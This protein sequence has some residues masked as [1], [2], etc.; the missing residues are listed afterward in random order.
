MLR[1]FKG[2]EIG[3]D[4]LFGLQATDVALGLVVGERHVLLKGKGKPLVTRRLSRLRPLE[5]LGFPLLPC[6]GGGSS[7][8]AA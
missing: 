6:L 2:L 7:L 3:G 4:L 5:F 8:S 1:P